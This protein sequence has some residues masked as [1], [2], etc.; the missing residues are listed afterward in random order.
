MW[1]DYYYLKNELNPK[2]IQHARKNSTSSNYMN[3]NI[4]FIC[5]KYNQSCEIR[6]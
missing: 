3:F 1:I 4:L 6:Q 5:V 2:K